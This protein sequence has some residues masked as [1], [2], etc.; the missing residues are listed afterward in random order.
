MSAKIQY[1]ERN[2]ISPNYSFQVCRDKCG[3]GQW[4]PFTHQDF[5]KDLHYGADSEEL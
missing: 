4:F 3:S 1:V 2:V 5:G